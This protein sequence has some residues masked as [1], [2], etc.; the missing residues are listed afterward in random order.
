MRYFIEETGE[1]ENKVRLFISFI[2]TKRKP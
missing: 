2:N 1:G